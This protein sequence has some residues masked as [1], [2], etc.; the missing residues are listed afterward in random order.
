MHQLQIGKE[1]AY[2]SDSIYYVP[3]EVSIETSRTNLEFHSNDAF[4]S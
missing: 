2:P 1:E 3:A 4:H